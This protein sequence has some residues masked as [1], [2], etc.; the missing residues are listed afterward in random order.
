MDV[1]AD[2]TSSVWNTNA[3]TAAGGREWLFQPSSS[4]PLEA[5]GWMVGDRDR[6]GRTGGLNFCLH[7]APLPRRD[8]RAYCQALLGELIAPNH[9]LSLASY[10]EMNAVSDK[11]EG[12]LDVSTCVYMIYFLPALGQESESVSLIFCF[13]HLCVVWH[14]IWYANLNVE[15]LKP[16]S[17]HQAKEQFLKPIRKLALTLIKNYINIYLETFT[18]LLNNGCSIHK[19]FNKHKPCFKVLVWGINLHHLCCRTNV[20]MF[21]QIIAH[22]VLTCDSFLKYNNL[23]S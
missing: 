12:R 2:E 23:Q 10:R 6:W 18:L 21:L 1:A 3:V 5:L 4:L 17:M 16:H 22:C 9:A 14:C 15:L 13:L 11:A 7:L 20:K 8:L 19:P